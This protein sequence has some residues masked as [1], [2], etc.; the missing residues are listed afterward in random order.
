MDSIAS[1]ASLPHGF[2]A[3]FE[4]ALSDFLLKLGALL[5]QNRGSL[6]LMTVTRDPGGK[7][8]IRIVR[9]DGSQG[10]RSVYCFVGVADGGIY[11][12]AG[13]ASPAPTA[14]GNIYNVD[15]LQ[16]CGRF[17]VAYLNN[18]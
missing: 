15:Q 7:K 12:P 14:R 13:W 10:G 16:G 18:R 6:P 9:S 5:N 11:K 1:A 2:H 3:S 8:Y 17:G 4:V